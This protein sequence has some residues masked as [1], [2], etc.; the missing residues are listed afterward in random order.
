MPA[1]VSI[2]Q[3]RSDILVYT[4]RHI[5]RSSSSYTA[6]PPLQTPRQALSQSPK[7]TPTSWSTQSGKYQDPGSLSIAV[8]PLQIPRQASP[9]LPKNTPIYAFTPLIG[10]Q[11]AVAPPPA[12]FFPAGR[13]LSFW[14]LVEQYATHNQKSI[15]DPSLHNAKYG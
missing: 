10:T 13:F 15:S 7:N 1:I 4:N 6:T 12:M 3:V 8:P 9:Q 14:A 11:K 5:S 2:A